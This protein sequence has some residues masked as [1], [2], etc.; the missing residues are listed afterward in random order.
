MKRRTATV[1][2]DPIAQVGRVFRLPRGL[3]I[4]EAAATT[5]L[6]LLDQVVEDG[7]VTDNEREALALFARAC[8][9]NRDV[10]RQL[11]LAYLEEMSRVARLDG[12]VTAE[13]HAYLAELAPMLSA[14]LPT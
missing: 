5:Y 3:G 12:V 1:E 7:R 11:H 2:A 14:A 13:E 6:G 10:A 4:P 9:I 8:G